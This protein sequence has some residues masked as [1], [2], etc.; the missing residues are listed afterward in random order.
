MKRQPPGPKG[1]FL[2]GSLL[3]FR[4][5]QLGFLPQMVQTYGDIV[6]FRL[7]NI[8][9]YLLGSPEY[10]HEV[11]VAQ[12]DKFEKSQLDKDILG[13]F[14]GNGLLISD[15]S[16]WRRQRRLA[17]PA[18][19]SKRIQGYAE[20]MVGYA[21]RM[22]AGWQDGERRDIDREMSRLTMQV[23]AKTLFDA[24]AV[25]AEENTAEMIGKA[26]ADLQ[27]VSNRDYRRGMT[28]PEWLPT[29]DNRKRRRAATVFNQ[30]MEK[31][32][33]ARRAGARD[34]KIADNGD[35]LSMLMLAQ[36]DDGEYMDDEQLRNEVATIFAAGHETTA[37]ALTW[38]F[39]LLAQ[40]PEVEAR[41]HEEVDRVLAGRAPTLDDLPNLPYTLMV[42]KEAM[43]L[44]PPAWILNGRTAIE[45]VVIGGYTIP[46]GAIIFIAP[47]VMHRLPQYF[48]DPER[49]DPERFT[50]AREKALPKF[51]YMPFGGGPRVCIGN[52]FALMEGHLILATVAQQFRLRLQPGFEVEMASL[53]TLTPKNGMPMSLERRRRVAE[54]RPSTE[55]V[56]VAT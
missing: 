49:F 8:P 53:I 12:A 6:Y 45:D 15:G 33:A 44:Y 5:D 9:I 37:N 46:R 14:L 30:Y 51:A 48:P 34:G 29:A 47:Y 7:L 1:H 54:Q 3:E 39:Y 36:D 55:A 19:H 26:V 16:F 28:L 17:Q 25:T 40:H 24:D 50:P 32:I 4:R 11:L 35:L 13:K 22:L 20:V 56:G 31:I 10:V 43:R 18:F 52:S 41:L 21:E 42:I 38:T 23:V 27:D 2:L